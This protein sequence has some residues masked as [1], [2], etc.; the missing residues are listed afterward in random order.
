LR[1]AGL[2]TEAIEIDRRLATLAARNRR[3]PH[4]LTTSEV[5]RV[6]ASALRLGSHEAPLRGRTVN[7]MIVLGYCAG[8]RLGETVRLQIRDLDHEEQTIEI[9]DSKFFKSRL[10]PLSA[11][12][13][14]SL[15]RYLDARRRHGGPQEATAPFFWN[16]SRRTGY[17][18]TVARR[19]IVAAMRNSGVKASRGPTGPRVHDLRHTFA[20]HRL[21]QWYR[22]GQD[23]TK[24]LPVL[25]TYLGHVSVEG[26]RTYISSTADLLSQA[27]ERLGKH[28]R[29]LRW[30][31]RHATRRTIQ[32]Q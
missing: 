6:L 9:R 14:A 25:S 26:T 22:D 4:V 12:V 16:A 18:S 24:L 13:W 15:V 20:V 11:T 2:E 10:L 1:R 23:V 28:V 27:S 29:H 19:W 3:Q 8:L 31:S 32:S 17:S 30:E 5:D 21:T 7:T